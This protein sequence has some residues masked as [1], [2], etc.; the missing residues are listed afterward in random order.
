LDQQRERATERIERLLAAARRIADSNDPLAVRARVELARTTGLSPQGI[1]CAIQNCLETNPSADEV[2]R[3]IESVPRTTRAHVLLPS[4]VF[5]AAHRAIALAL[6]A[7]AS[8]V[9]RPSRRDPVLA[10]LLAEAAPGLFQLTSETLEPAPGEHLWAYGT[11]ATLGA[12]RRSLPTNV[13]LH[14]HGP[15]VGV[16]LVDAAT[17]QSSLEQAARALALDVIL[18][19][20]R[21]CLSPRLGLVRGDISETRRFARLLAA[22][23]TE[24]EH[25][26]PRGPLTSQE[27]ADL[28]RFRDTMTYSGDVLGAGSGFV[29]AVPA[30][31]SGSGGFITAVG[32]S[33]GLYSVLDESAYLT[34]LAAAITTV[35]VSAGPEVV[36]RLRR[37]LPQTRVTRLGAMQTPPFDGPADRRAQS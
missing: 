12:L 34:S 31:E 9:V 17:D 23:L 33:L 1:D 11:D 8:V 13:V 28:A 30:T 18:F 15:G 37:L 6:A 5:V 27:A 2:A 7:S 3:L 20:Q 22:A 21:G 26:V 32:R 25:D 4:N 24:L 29:A 14:A 36:E 19:D 16:A 35:G 10:T